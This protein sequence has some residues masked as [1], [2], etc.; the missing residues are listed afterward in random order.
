[1]DLEKLMSIE[2]KL[3]ILSQFKNWSLSFHILDKNYLNKKNVEFILLELDLNKQELQVK[4][5]SK[6]QKRK[7]I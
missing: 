2:K 7:S 3:N 6:N 4:T 1:M 5:F